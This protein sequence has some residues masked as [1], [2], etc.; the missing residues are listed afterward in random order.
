M[1]IAAKFNYPPANGPRCF[2]SLVWDSDLECSGMKLLGIHEQTALG[3]LTL[4]K[5]LWYCKV[6]SYLKFPKYSIWI[7]G[8]ETHLTVF[9]AKDMALFDPEAPS[10]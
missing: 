1:G 6:D 4:M 7:A 3:F 2:E 8:S 9:F 10:E 5:P